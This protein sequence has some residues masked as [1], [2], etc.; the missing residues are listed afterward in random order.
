MKRLLLFAAVF[1]VSIAP[2]TLLA[3]A[4]PQTVDATGN[5]LLN[6][7]YFVRQILFTNL[8]NTGAIGKARS[9]SG[10]ASFDGNG[11]YTLTG[12]SSDSTSNAGQPQ[13]LNF[14]GSYSV[15]SG[16]LLQMQNPLD[17]AEIV[18]GGVGVSAIV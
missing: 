2:L 1:C 9:L 17:P 5:S 15:T 16:G 6:G 7:N 8:T 4:V 10:M 11:H 13:A 12:Q 14:S 3:E 18:A